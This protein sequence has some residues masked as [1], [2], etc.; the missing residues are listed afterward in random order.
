MEDDQD[1]PEP[2]LTKEDTGQNQE[3]EQKQPEQPSVEA[4][5]DNQEYKYSEKDSSHNIHTAPAAENRMGVA[6]WLRA[7]KWQTNPFIFNIN[8]SL[9]VGY[10]NQTDRVMMALEEKHKIILVLGPTGSGKTTLMRW[11]QSRL[12]KYEVLYIG[13]PPQKAEEAF[14]QWAYAFTPTSMRS[15]PIP[16]RA[17][18]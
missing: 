9:F 18:W 6:D 1:E 3:S 12:K 5:V 2:S 4:K 11:L 14:R 7:M 13:K 8:P 10:R 16:R 15:T 17:P